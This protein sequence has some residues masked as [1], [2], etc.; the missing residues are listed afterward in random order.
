MVCEI[1]SS[2]SIV[3]N[4][5]KHSKVFDMMWM[6]IRHQVSGSLHLNSTSVYC[7]F[8]IQQAVQQIHNRTEVYS[9]SA[10]NL[11]I[12]STKN[13]KPITNLQDCWNFV[14]S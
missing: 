10:K 13:Q 9:K 7:E 11:H 12:E 5:T 2:T 3:Q 1:C 6:W 4:L 8:V 14:M